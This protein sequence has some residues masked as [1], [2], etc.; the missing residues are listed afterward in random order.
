MGIGRR[1]YRGDIEVHGEFA[2]QPAADVTMVMLALIPSVIEI[3]GEGDNSRLVS[4]DHDR[5]A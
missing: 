1:H 4:N 2:V 3:S 5:G